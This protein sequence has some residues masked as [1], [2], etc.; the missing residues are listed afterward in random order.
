M[1]TRQLT[2]GQ[3]GA[4]HIR[5]RLPHVAVDDA[6]EAAEAMIEFLAPLFCLHGLED[7]DT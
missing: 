2:V 1:N 3:Q 6:L 5:A 7:D 4:E